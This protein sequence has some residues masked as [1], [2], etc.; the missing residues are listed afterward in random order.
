MKNYNLMMNG[1]KLM[2]F[3][4]R[5]GATTVLKALNS[6]NIVDNVLTFFGK[7]VL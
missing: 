7:S 2:A 1:Q 3:R 6:V 4:D 5:L